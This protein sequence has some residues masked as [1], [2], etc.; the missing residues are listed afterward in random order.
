MSGGNV[1]IVRRL[2]AD[3][4]AGE[5]DA[6]FA[7][8]DPEI[9][10]IEPHGYFTGAGGVRGVAA[11]GDVLAAYPA[12]WSDFALEPEAFLDAGDDVV[13]TGTQRG[14]SLATGRSFAGRFCNV[15][16]LRD[17]RVVRFE[18]FADTALIREA[19][20]ADRTSGPAT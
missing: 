15:W 14:V 12:T 20:A 6:V 2:F 4:A 16:T 10:W 8:F 18:A 13:V 1:E 9:E 5:I 3:F 7:V 11:V 19:L 17:G